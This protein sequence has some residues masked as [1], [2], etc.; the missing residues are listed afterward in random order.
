MVG[1]W[2]GMVMHPVDE[3]WALP[4]MG[5]D[6]HVPLMKHGRIYLYE[7]LVIEPENGALVLRLGNST[8]A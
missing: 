2:S 4:A 1:S 8:W 3:H 7:L 6:G 5:D